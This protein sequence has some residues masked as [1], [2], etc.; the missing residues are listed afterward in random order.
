MAF[1][2]LRFNAKLD[3]FVFQDM[4]PVISD[5]CLPSNSASS[6]TIV[7]HSSGGNSSDF[8]H[9]GLAQENTVSSDGSLY[10]KC[11]CLLSYPSSVAKVCRA[12][13]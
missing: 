3:A 10:Q 2:V 4:R 11:L 7:H 13:T 1:L 8:D 5:M 6:A 12:A 9:I